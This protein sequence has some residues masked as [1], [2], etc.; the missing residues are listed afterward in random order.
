[1]IFGLF[2]YALSLRDLTTSKPGSFSSFKDK[3][4]QKEKKEEAEDEDSVEEVEVSP[5]QQLL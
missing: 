1:M 4:A 3:L 5:I 2:I